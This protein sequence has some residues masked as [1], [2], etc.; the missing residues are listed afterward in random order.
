MRFCMHPVFRLVCWGGGFIC[1]HR[2]F[3]GQILLREAERG[4]DGERQLW[5]RSRR[6]RLAAVQQAVSRT[7]PDSL[8][9][10]SGVCVR[11]QGF[12]HPGGVSAQGRSVRLPLLRQ[13]DHEAKVWGPARRG[14]QLHPLPPEQVPGLQVNPPPSLPPHPTVLR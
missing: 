5:A 4:G 12:T 2:R 10:S 9:L 7:L 11:H 6:P 1:V 13:R 3:G 14:D 8:S